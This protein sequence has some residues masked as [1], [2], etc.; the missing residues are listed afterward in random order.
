[1]TQHNLCLFT[2][3]LAWT[4]SYST[5]CTYL[6]AVRFRN[7]E[8]GFYSNFEPMQ[9]LQ[10]LLRG[11]KHVKGVSSRPSRLRITLNII[12]ILK[13][14][15]QKSPISEKDK[16]MLWAAV[17][18][19]F[20]GR[21]RSSEFCC[22]TKSTFNPNET[23]L[24]RDVNLNENVATIQIKVSKADPFR[25]GHEVCIAAS[26]SS[27]CAFRALSK[28]MQFCS[29]PAVPLFIFSDSTYLTRQRVTKTMQS[30]LGPTFPGV[31]RYSSH[32]LRIGG[33]TSAAA[34]NLP[35]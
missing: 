35:D 22:E 20:F 23:L 28:Y 19:A 18:T 12:K 14:S 5:I 27:V 13:S 33:A 25:N 26:Q 17:T 2:T 32:S 9:N 34:A 1:M 3:Y 10:M 4:L 16:L 31:D 30:L 8:L 15:L 6:A 7:I 11:I 29:C 21:L 24:L